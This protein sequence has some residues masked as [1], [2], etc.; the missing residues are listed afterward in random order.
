MVMNEGKLCLSEEIRGLFNQI[1]AARLPTMEELEAYLP[2]R[3]ASQGDVEAIRVYE[4]AGVLT[5]ELRVRSGTREALRKAVYSLEGTADA[6]EVERHRLSLEVDA[7]GDA[8][9]R[10]RVRF[11]PPR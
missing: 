9:R 2:V 7:E 4:D 5:A 1:S 10:V 8:V 3:A 11:G 6:P